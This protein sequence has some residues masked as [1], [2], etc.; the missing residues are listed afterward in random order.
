MVILIKS[1]LLLGILLALFLNI[2]SIHIPQTEN[3][4]AY[5]SNQLLFTFFTIIFWLPI[6]VIVFIHT[7]DNDT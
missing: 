7:K 4:E 2:V 3:T 5:K 1:Y 6:L